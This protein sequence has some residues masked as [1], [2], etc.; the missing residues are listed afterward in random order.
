[1]VIA[2][3]QIESKKPDRSAT[4]T[5]MDCGSRL[6]CTGLALVAVCLTNTRDQ[7]LTLGL[8]V[9]YGK[10]WGDRLKAGASGEVAVEKF[11]PWYLPHLAVWLRTTGA[12]S[13]PSDR[14]RRPGARVWL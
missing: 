8:S 7:S 1:M 3:Q 9:K 12:D 13:D 14:R 2:A 10:V 6:V 4:P 11:G 5:R